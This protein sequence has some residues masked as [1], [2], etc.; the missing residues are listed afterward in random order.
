[1]LRTN[2]VTRTPLET[3]QFA[4]EFGLKL[5]RGDVV[6]LYGDLGA[7]KTQFVKGVCEAFG[8]QTPVTSPTFVLLN[9]Y[10]GRD[11]GG[12]ELLLYH[13]DLYRI[14]SLEEVYD[15]GYEEFFYGNGIC[16]IEWA[17]LLGALLPPVRYDVRIS[18][19]SEEFHRRIELEQVRSQSPPR[20]FGQAVSP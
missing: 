8:V 10:Q 5:R 11:S 14:K 13:L 15:I 12:E 6:A 7:G 19:G 16:L 1:M 20:R 17:E 9:R 4:R 18:G 2:S 3:V